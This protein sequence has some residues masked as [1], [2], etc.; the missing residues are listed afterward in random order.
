MLKYQKIAKNIEQYIKENHLKQGDKLPSLEEF[1]TYFGASK[2]TI[3]RSL[4]LLENKGTVYGQHGSGIFVHTPKR[5]DYIDLS[6]NRGFSHEFSDYEL[7]NKVLMIETKKATSD[8]A[9]NLNITPSELI[10][11]VKRLIFID[12]RPLGIEESHYVQAV[13]PH[14]DEEVVSASIFGYLQKKL[15]L[16]FGFS[17]AY[18][19]IGKL[20][21][22]EAKLL[23]LRAGDPR[24]CL[25]NTFYLT[26]R[27][28]FN[29]SKT[30]FHYEQSKFF[31]PVVKNL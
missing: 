16:K 7:T 15:K 10:H 25:I 27:T 9:Q 21:K 13:V 24:P 20:N 14:L 6:F 19:I 11:Y 2:S 5:K 28:P 8:V 12:G 4:G 29:Y 31:I 23:S 22:E 3:R 1:V 26:D 17:D 30:V 18:L